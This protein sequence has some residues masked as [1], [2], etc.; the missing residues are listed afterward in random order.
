MQEKLTTIEEAVIKINDGDVVALQTMATVASP[1]ALV[2]E[3]IRQQKKKLGLVVLIGGIP[4]DWLAATGVINRLIGAAVTME[5]FGLCQQYR[6]A[7]EQGRIRVEEI[8]E[9][10]LNARLGAGARNL[11]FLP[12]RGAIGT[13]LMQENPDNMKLLDDPFGGLPVIA[14]RAL[15]PDVALIHAHRAD[16]FGNIQYEPT[17]LWPDLGIMPKAAK[18]V[19]VS[20]E[21]IVDTEVLRRNPDRTVLPGFMVDAVVE[22]PY[23]AHPTSFYP[24]YGYDSAFHREWTSVSR[25]NEKTTEFIERYVQSPADQAEYL[26]AIGGE[27]VLAHIAK[28]EEA[29]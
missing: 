19:I 17:A 11:P 23:G 2:R 26:E 25:D 13:D 9:S 12:T 3:M 1:M 16:R 15:V 6:Q 27:T 29:E 24:N 8:S 4:V 10:V 20:V 14:C 28:W 5:Q 21:E 18:Q 22:V 7:V